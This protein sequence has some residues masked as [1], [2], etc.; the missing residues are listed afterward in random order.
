MES[1]LQFIV[2]A[3]C[4]PDCLSEYFSLAVY[5]VITLILFNKSP[6]LVY[7]IVENGMLE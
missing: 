1:A 7:T 4:L 5:W 2:L 3:W 6:M